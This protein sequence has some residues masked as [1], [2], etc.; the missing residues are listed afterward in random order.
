MIHSLRKPIAVVV[1]DAGAANHILA[2]I[3]NLGNEPIRVCAKGPALTI[4]KIYF[5][6]ANFF[7]NVE[8]T[9]DGAATL[10]S[11]TGW[12]SNLE[13]DARK[14]AKN[15]RI[16]SIAM[17]D[18]WTNYSARFIRDGVEVLPEDI[19]VTDEHAKALAIQTFPNVNIIQILN[20]YLDTLVKEVHKFECL[21]SKRDT[22]NLLYVLE[23]VRDAWGPG[24]VAGEFVAL[25]YFISNL[26]LLGLG[27]DL[28]IRLR[29]HPSDP[30]GKYD[31]WIEDQKNVQIFLDENRSLAEAIACADVVVGCQTYAMVIA[32]AAGKKVFSSN[33]PN[34]LPCLLPQKGI[35]S[36][37]SLSTQKCIK[38]Q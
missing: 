3:K 14:I 24:N 6:H 37:S 36:L 31:Q 8:N 35:V 16:K 20:L 23:P 29:P 33:P 30:I 1:H 4:W 27:H 7:D 22:N 2:M 38:K 19:W 18:H 17:V 32:L 9:L 25:N 34:V 21:Q 11:G 26:E 10:I 13:H 15:L 5:P 28:T 12:A